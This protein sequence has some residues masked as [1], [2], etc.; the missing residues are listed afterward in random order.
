MNEQTIKGMMLLKRTNELR[1]SSQIIPV[2]LVMTI[3]TYRS[4]SISL[5][6]TSDRIVYS[7][8][9]G[10]IWSKHK[11]LRTIDFMSPPTALQWQFLN[12]MSIVIINCH[13]NARH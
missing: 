2:T 3:L 8:E 1:I 13:L 11:T 9:R 10:T 12:Q 5:E 4:V 6:I 7:F